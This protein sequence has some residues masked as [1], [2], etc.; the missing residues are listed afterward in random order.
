M[1]YE[2][3]L[4]ALDELA[5]A[6]CRLLIIE[7]GEPFLWRDGSRNLEDVVRAARARGFARVGISTNGTLPIETSADMVWVSIDGMQDAHEANRGPVWDR[8]MANL[9][10]S[11]HPKL[12]AQV[13]VSRIN[14]QDVPK[15]VFYLAKRVQGVTVQFFYPYPDSDDLWLPWPERRWVLE[16]LRLL[17]RQGYP[18]VDSDRVLRDLK[19]NHWSCHDWLI[20]NAEPDPEDPTRALV[21]FGCYLKGRAQ[22]DCSRCGFT[23]HAELSLAYDLHPGALWTGQQVFAFLG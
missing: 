1:S 8:V 6:G 12:L 20:A 21:R 19:D 22:A 5:T 17:K 7:G 10:A 18:V 23:A 14:W 15:I 13:T 3:V 16:Q 11:P 4:G 9:A 2:A